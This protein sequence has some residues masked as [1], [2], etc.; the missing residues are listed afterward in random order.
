MFERGKIEEAMLYYLYMMSDGEVS[1]SEEK[2]FAEICSEM[3]VN[4]EEK[5]AAIGRCKEIA[6]NPKAAF[7]VIVSEKLDDQIRKGLFYDVFHINKDMS[8]LTRIIWNLI[9]LGYADAYYSE[10]EKRIVNHLIEKWGIKPEVYQEMVD[11]ADAMLALTKQKEWVVLTFDKGSLRDEK[12]RK[13]DLEIGAML[14]DIKLTID[15]LTM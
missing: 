7:D 2:L 10:D 11:T 13:I 15:E 8:T 4:E 12:E 1:Y 6:K 14:S 5:Q 9:N 3:N